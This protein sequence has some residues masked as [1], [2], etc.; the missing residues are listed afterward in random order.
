MV[1]NW[2]ENKKGKTLC[3]IPE[4]GKKNNWLRRKE[5]GRCNNENN[6]L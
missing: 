5:K 3:R 1:K 4:F 6:Y 2:K